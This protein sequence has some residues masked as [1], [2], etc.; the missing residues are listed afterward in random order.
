M[1]CPPLPPAPNG[2]G[3]RVAQK[4]QSGRPNHTCFQAAKSLDLPLRIA[5]PV[6]RAQFGWFM[7]AIPVIAYWAV[8]ALHPVSEAPAA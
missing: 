4:S 5:T 1:A 7:G 2:Q 6:T 3:F 8:D